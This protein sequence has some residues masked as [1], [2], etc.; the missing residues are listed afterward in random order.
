MVDALEKVRGLLKPEGII[1]DAHD[2]PIPRRLTVVNS[3]QSIDAGHLVDRCDFDKVRRTDE[4]VEHVDVLLHS[5]PTETKTS[6]T[7]DTS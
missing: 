1:I 6:I 2:K 3:G 4:A 5:V 7:G